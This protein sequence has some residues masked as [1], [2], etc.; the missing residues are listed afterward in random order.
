MLT[1]GLPSGTLQ[2]GTE[3]PAVPG[4]VPQPPPEQEGGE[5]SRMSWVEQSPCAH[6]GDDP[7]NTQP[8]GAVFTTGTIRASQPAPGGVNME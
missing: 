6:R 5:L 3:P 7:A 4:G 1:P 2:N 8:L